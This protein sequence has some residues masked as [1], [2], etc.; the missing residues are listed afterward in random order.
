MRHN[1]EQSFAWALDRGYLDLIGLESLWRYLECDEL[2]NGLD[3]FTFDTGLEA[4]EITTQGWLMLVSQ[5]YGDEPVVIIER[6]EF[7]RR[8]RLKVDPNWATLG[9]EWTNRINR[10]KRKALQIAAQSQAKG[11]VIEGKLVHAEV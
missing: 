9:Q 1:R 2:S 8:R 10:A 6:L 11:A 7:L 4:G 3:F 5:T